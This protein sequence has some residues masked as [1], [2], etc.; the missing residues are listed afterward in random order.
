ML[1]YD[2]TI[3][4]R[5]S[6]C[7]T[8]REQVQRGGKGTRKE[9]EEGGRWGLTSIQRFSFH[10]LILWPVVW[11]RIRD[12]SNSLNAFLF[13]FLSE[14]LSSDLVEVRRVKKTEDWDGENTCS[15][16]CVERWRGQSS[17]WW[18]R[19]P[20]GGSVAVAGGCCRY[21]DGELRSDGKRKTAEFRHKV[22]WLNMSEISLSS[23]EV[24]DLQKILHNFQMHSRKEW[25]WISSRETRRDED[26]RQL[27]QVTSSVIGNCWVFLTTLC[28]PR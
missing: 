20:H 17:C 2:A 9:R 16:R 13:F 1:L 7:A 6:E 10:Q 3:W 4:K 21:I 15:R 8:G 27:L 5:G 22:Q 28:K 18:P 23:S 24:F 14:L 19:P 11:G 26:L 12:Q 25:C